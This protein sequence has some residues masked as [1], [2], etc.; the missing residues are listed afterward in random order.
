VR[1]AL[2]AAGMLST[3]CAMPIPVP[4]APLVAFNPEEVRWAA[5][6]GTSTIEGQAFMKARGGDVKYGAGSLVLLIPYSA[7]SFAWYKARIAT[8][9]DIPPM[10]PALQALV[11]A[12]TAGRDGRFKFENEPAGSYLVVTFV[13]WETGASYAVT[14]GGYI[15]MPV[16]AEA[17]KTAKII[18]TR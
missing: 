12:T 8:L 2:L 16:T 10:D 15:G 7:Q 1:L 17:G 14:Q 13:T 6:P 11:K 3:A 4:P 9:R 5:L 18:V